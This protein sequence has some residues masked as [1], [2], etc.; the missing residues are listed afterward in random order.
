MRRSLSIQDKGCILYETGLVKF[1]VSIHMSNL[2]QVVTC[3]LYSVHFN[4]SFSIQG[5]S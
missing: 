4:K 2:V 5:F 3:S 1:L